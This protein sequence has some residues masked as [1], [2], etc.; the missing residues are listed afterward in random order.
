MVR[1]RLLLEGRYLPSCYK[2]MF[3]LTISPYQERSLICATTRTWS[4]QTAL[5]SPTAIL[6]A[7][8]P[9]RESTNCS[10]T[11]YRQ[12]NRVTRMHSRTDS[13]SMTSSASWTSGRPPYYCGLRQISK[14]RWKI[15]LECA[16]RVSCL[17]VLGSRR[18]IIFLVFVFLC[19]DVL[20]NDALVL[21]VVHAMRMV[22]W[23]FFEYFYT[24]YARLI[25]DELDSPLLS[26]KEWT[27]IT[28]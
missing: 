18:A 17:W 4:Q 26:S 21:S 10:W 23:R 14:R 6:T 2:R 25:E 7:P 1:Q 12:S 9:P 22:C 16:I 19:F 24:R 27:I 8:L 20:F 28:R 11:S 5:S 3:N 15:S 13:S